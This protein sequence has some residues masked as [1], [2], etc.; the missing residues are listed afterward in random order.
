[1]SDEVDAVDWLL[2]E[3]SLIALAKPSVTSAI[4]RNRKIKVNSHGNI[5]KQNLIQGHLT[6]ITYK[7][8]IQNRCNMFYDLIKD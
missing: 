8:Y 5:M 6:F 3:K 2:I 4:F 7:T 1:M